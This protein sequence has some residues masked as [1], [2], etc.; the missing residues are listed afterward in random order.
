MEAKPHA[1]PM[2]F[3]TKGYEIGQYAS[4][5]RCSWILTGTTVRKRIV[6]TIHDSSIDDALFSRCNSSKSPEIVRWCG[7]NHPNAIMSTTD[8]LYVYFQSD[9]TFQGRGINMSF[10]EFETSECPPSWISNSAGYCYVLKKPVDG[11]TWVE[12]QKECTLERS[13]LLTLS[14]ANEYSFITATYAKNKTFPWIG[15]TDFNSEGDF[16]AVDPSSGPWPEDIPKISENHPIQDCVY[17]DWSNRDGKVFAVDDCRNRH[18][19]LCKR[20]RGTLVNSFLD[21]LTI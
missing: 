14:S 10:V 8:S 18:E 3:H 1:Q 13:N 20:R 15:Y 21:L 5:M 16:S 6:L 19:Y 9:E 12:A 11:L 4:N 2:Y 7:D 17:M